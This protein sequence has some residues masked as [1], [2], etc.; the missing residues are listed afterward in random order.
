MTRLT[1]F[2]AAH[3]AGPINFTRTKAAGASFC[4]LKAS[5]GETFTDPM[6][7][8]NWRGATKAGLKVGAYHFFDPSTD[9]AAQFEHFLHVTGGKLGMSGGIMPSLDV[10]QVG[11]LSPE[12]YSKRCRV[13]IDLCIKNFGK[14]PIFYTYRSFAEHS[15]A[16]NLGECP[17]WAAS[18][19]PH[20]DPQTGKPVPFPGWDEWSFWQY[21]DDG[22]LAGIPGTHYADLD[23]MN[24]GDWHPH[25]LI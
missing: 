9:P 4:I 13:W 15:L 24:A 16:P 8:T 6:F 21:Q 11:D 1:G 18:Y 10:E 12:E 20:A 19:P 17:L 7:H 23:V 2:D 22:N 5:Q 25:L 14:P 3:L